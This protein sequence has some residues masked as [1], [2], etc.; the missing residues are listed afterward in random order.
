MGEKGNE[1]LFLNTK[2]LLEYFDTI[3]EPLKEE[4]ALKES[5]ATCSK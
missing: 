3:I 5:N 4:V 1:E 2:L